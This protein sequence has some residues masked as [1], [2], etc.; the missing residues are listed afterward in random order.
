MNGLEG[1]EMG[2]RTKKQDDRTREAITN[3]IERRSRLR[4]LW[5]HTD[6]QLS[7]PFGNDFS[8]DV[9]QGQRR[10]SHILPDRP[11]GI[12]YRFFNVAF[13][14]LSLHILLI[15]HLYFCS[16]NRFSRR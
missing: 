13:Q 7:L 11:L 3:A 1:A 14:D 12:S 6:L 5:F 2:R 9:D 4:Q 15:S 8:I 10:E 16:S